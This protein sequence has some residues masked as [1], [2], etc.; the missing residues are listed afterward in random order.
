MPLRPCN[1]VGC[2]NLVKKGYCNKHPRTD[3]VIR[4]S[5][6][7]ERGTSHQRGYGARW[8]RYRVAYLARNPLCKMHGEKGE[9]KE[10]TVVD[11]KTPVSGP[12]DPLFWDES[13]HQSL[14]RDCHQ[15]KTRVIDKKGF[16]AVKQKG[17]G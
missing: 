15:Y 6:D 8:R 1:K 4:N 10:A 2:P 5:R 16:G 13:N 3:P 11:H 7:R 14:C 9:L 17:A 12:D